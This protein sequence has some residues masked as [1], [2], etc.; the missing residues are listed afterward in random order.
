MDDYTDARP[1]APESVSFSRLYESIKDREVRESLEE[2]LYALGLVRDLIDRIGIECDLQDE[3]DRVPDTVSFEQLLNA[4]GHPMHPVVQHCDPCSIFAPCEGCV[5]ISLSNIL[6]NK[7]ISA[8]AVAEAL[9]VLC[10]CRHRPRRPRCRR[11]ARKVSTREAI[12]Q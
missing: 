2:A 5:A 1:E 12:L 4:M 9:K 10:R 6:Y 7:L 3:T 11:A 8:Q